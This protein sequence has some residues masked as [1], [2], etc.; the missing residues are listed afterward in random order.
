MSRNPLN[1]KQIVEAALKLV[2][3]D[4]LDKLSMRKLG[5]QLG[6]EAMSLYHHVRDKDDLLDALHEHLLGKLRWPDQ[7]SGP[8]WEQAAE[9]ARQFRALL[10][11][12]PQAIPLFAS[13]SAIAPGSLQLVEG[14]LQLLLAAGFT[15]AQAIFGFQNLFCFT[16]GHA[17]FHN[18][19]RSQNSYARAQD[20]QDHGALSRLGDPSHLSADEEFEFGLDNLLSGLRSRLSAV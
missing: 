2:A 7:G 1:R 15:P 20:Y 13:R 3:Q 16:L 11:G 18:A 6:V 19:P 4:G 17:I 12:Y 8:W 14:S 5:Q 10:S 9:V